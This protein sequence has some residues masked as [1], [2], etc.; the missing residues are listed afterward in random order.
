MLM[1]PSTTIR[2][3]GVYLGVAGITLLWRPDILFM[4]VGMA[5]GPNELLVL[6]G[7]VMILFSIYYLNATRQNCRVFAQG[8]VLGRFVIFGIVV[9]AVMTGQLAWNYLLIVGL[10]PLGAIWTAATLWRTRTRRGDAAQS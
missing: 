1:A 8:T 5:Y 6:L 2:V 7:G 3:F 9:W 4:M 10:E